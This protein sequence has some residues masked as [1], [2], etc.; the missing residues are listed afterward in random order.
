MNYRKKHDAISI[1]NKTRRIS[2]YLD[3]C[4]SMWDFSLASLG[5]MLLVKFASASLVNKSIIRLADET[6]HN[7]IQSGMKKEKK[8]FEMLLSDNERK[9]H[10]LESKQRYLLEDKDTLQAR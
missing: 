8:M 1:F 6:I 9:F 10:E 7:R 4:T 3:K 2:V 5:G